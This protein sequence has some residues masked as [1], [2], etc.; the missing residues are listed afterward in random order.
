MKLKEKNRDLDV[1][2][3]QETKQEITK[4]IRKL[5]AQIHNI[6]NQENQK[7]LLFKAVVADWCASKS[8]FHKF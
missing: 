7:V 2:E 8:I 6:R 4:T 3:T 5:N 1:A